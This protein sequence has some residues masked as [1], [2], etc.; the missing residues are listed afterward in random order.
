MQTGRLR[1]VPYTFSARILSRFRMRPL[2]RVA[3]Y[4]DARARLLRRLDQLF[5]GFYPYNLTIGQQEALNDHVWL[6]PL[7]RMLWTGFASLPD[8]AWA[9][10]HWPCLP[11]SG[12]SA[13]ICG[14]FC[15]FSYRRI[16]APLAVLQLFHNLPAWSAYI[17]GCI[18]IASLVFSVLMFLAFLRMPVQCHGCRVLLVV[19]AVRNSLSDRADGQRCR[20]A[21]RRSDRVRR[22]SCACSQAS[23]RSCLSCIARR[24]NREAGILLVPAIVPAWPSMRSSWSFSCAHGPGTGAT[25][26]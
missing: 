22:R 25:L 26:R 16:N 2:P 5:P 7:A 1:L 13:N 20:I 17:G 10:S 14:F 18:Q 23:F 11:R 6:L 9:S 8:W 24:G 4:R 15:S 3:R 12:N 19:A 21:D